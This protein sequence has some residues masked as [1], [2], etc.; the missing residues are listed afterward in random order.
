MAVC[1]LAH[2]RRQAAIARLLEL[3]LESGSGGATA[4]PTTFVVI[5][6]VDRAPRFDADVDDDKASPLDSLRTLLRASATD[7]THVIGWWNSAASFNSHV[8][9]TV[10]GTVNGVVTMFL[11]SDELRQVF[12]PLGEWRAQPHRAIF[13]DK[14]KTEKPLKIIPFESQIGVTA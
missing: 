5:A 14:Q 13:W 11:A 2:R 8:D 4:T 9:Y 10:D 3:A 1:H 12:G 6:G 7:G